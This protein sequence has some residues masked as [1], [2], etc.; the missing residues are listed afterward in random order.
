[1]PACSSVLASGLAT[2]IE[3]FWFLR[4]GTCE[5]HPGAYEAASDGADVLHFAKSADTSLLQFRRL[6]PAGAV[7]SGWTAA[8]P[9]KGIETKS[10]LSGTFE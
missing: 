2:T 5:R 1:M 3:S 4:A 9:S 8:L 7:F 10:P 6:P